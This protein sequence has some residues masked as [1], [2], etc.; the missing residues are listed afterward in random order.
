MNLIDT[1]SHLY[2]EDYDND[3]DEVIATA[4]ANGVSRIFLPNIDI[5]T[6]PAMHNLAEKFPD[7]CI[8]MM[9][10]H[11]TSITSD[12]KNQLTQIENELN[13]RDYCAI[14][15]IGI[16]L[17]WDKTKLAE[18]QEAFRTQIRWAIELNLPI[19]IHVRDSFCETMSVLQEFDTSLLSGV[20]H[21]FCG[22]TDEAIEILKLDNFFF[23]INGIVT[24]KNSDLENVLKDVP[25]DRVV[26][27][28]DSPYLTPAPYRGKRNHPTYLHLIAKRLAEVYQLPVEEIAKRTSENAAKLFVKAF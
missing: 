26:L 13:K 2:A 18:Q 4:K 21:S 24:F 1:H 19:V 9:G 22:T 7:F 6:A 12:Y 5:E 11:P 10:I 25:L 16:D 15:E 28:T 8:P 20:F 27:E 23:G 3:I 17:Y 14:G